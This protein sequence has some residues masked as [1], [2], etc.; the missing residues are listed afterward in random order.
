MFPNPMAP[1]FSTDNVQTDVSGDDI[2]WA[3]HGSKFLGQRG[4]DDVLKMGTACRGI[5]EN[6]RAWFELHSPILRH[7][8][9]CGKNK[10]GEG[11]G[12]DHCRHL[13]LSR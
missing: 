10:Y 4:G 3:F 2:V 9:C 13:T 7:G 12:A 11:E 5:G 6:L 8:R 1:A